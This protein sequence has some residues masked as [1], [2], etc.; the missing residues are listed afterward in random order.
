MSKKETTVVHVAL[1]GGQCMT[2]GERG[3]EKEAYMK[4]GRKK[5]KEKKIIISGLAKKTQ[6][7]FERDNF[8]LFFEKI[9]D[10]SYFW[11]KAKRTFLR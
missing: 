4:K 7:A 10:H 1:V 2:F 5:E 6:Y 9:T 3:L 11:N 8:Q